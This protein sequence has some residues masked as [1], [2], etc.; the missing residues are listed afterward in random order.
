MLAVDDLLRFKRVVE[1]GSISKASRLL[2]VSQPALSRSIQLLEHEY[3]VELLERF[4]SGVTPTPFGRILYRAACDVERCYLQAEE[5]ILRETALH[6]PHPGRAQVQIGCSTIWNDF[7]FPEV[8]SSLDSVDQY[9]IHVTNDTSEQLLNDMLDSARYD[10]VLCRVVE[11]ER[12]RSLAWTPLLESRTAVFAKANH[13]AFN[14]EIDFDT[15][16]RLQFVKLKA[17]PTLQEA[18]LSVAGRT[19]VSDEFP[20]SSVSVEVEDLMAAIQL[21][22]G[23]HAIMLPLAFAGM[24]SEY[25]IKPLRFTPALTNPY[26]LGMASSPD[27]EAPTHVRELMNRTRQFSIDAVPAV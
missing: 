27:R 9:E 17:L 12:F 23:N 10:F 21:L 5:Q 22:R 14:S 8:L 1:A 2:F 6:A 4:P 11:D 13:E 15:L 20:P 26:W 3:G 7:L 25:N 16:Q 18:D 24:L 19:L